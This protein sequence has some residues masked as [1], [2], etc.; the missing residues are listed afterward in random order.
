MATKLGVIH[1]WRLSK[2]LIFGPPHSICDNI[3][4]QK[5]FIFWVWPP[6]MRDVTC[7][8]P[9]YIDLLHLHLRIRK[10]SNR[11]WTIR[12]RIRGTEYER[13]VHTYV[14]MKIKNWGTLQKKKNLVDVFNC[15]LQSSINNNFMFEIEIVHN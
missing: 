11:G 4:I 9:H 13:N 14:R 15:T 10:K 1:K 12:I 3:F 5:I 8:Q 7:I 6:K 2:Y